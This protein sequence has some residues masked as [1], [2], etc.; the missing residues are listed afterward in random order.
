M[1]K[2]YILHFLIATLTLN[3]QTWEAYTSKNNDVQKPYVQVTQNIAGDKIYSIAI[4]NNRIC[5]GTNGGVTLEDDGVFTYFNTSNSSL[6]ENTIKFTAFDSSGNAW[7][8]SNNVLTLYNGDSLKHF[9]Y[10]GRDLPFYTI[11]AMTVDTNGKLWLGSLGLGIFEY[12]GDDFI[13]H[14]DPDSVLRGHAVS[15]LLVDNN[16]SKWVGTAQYTVLDNGIGAFKYNGTEWE[17]FDHDNSG[18][19]SINIKSMEMEDDGTLWFGGY[20]WNG[21]T[22]YDGQQ[23]KSYYQKNSQI[24]PGSIDCIAIDTKGRKWFGNQS[25]GLSMYDGNKWTTFNT[26]NSQLESNQILSLEAH[27]D[28]SMYIGTAVGLSVY[29]DNI[30]NTVNE[31]N[32]IPPNVQLL[33]NYPN[34]FNGET[35]IQY[36]VENHA[37]IQI[38][39]YNTRGQL[40]NTL[41][42]GKQIPGQHAV[43]WNGKN[44]V[45]EPVSSGIYFV[46]LT[47]D[48]RN[49]ETKRLVFLK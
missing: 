23:W 39:I 22:R 9:T 6:P 8:A 32:K 5:Y 49:V 34:P 48:Q 2:Q 24:I 17:L 42:R 30:V 25:S 43:H 3:A 36:S 15:A 28:G 44:D 13:Q 37:D 10:T 31:S 27:P 45:G 35:T 41:F 12:N 47:T 40:I 38:R 7:F 1:K 46:R 19:Y 33:Q 29:N 18:I 16:D 20:E 21:V 14:L 26:V 11:T 4:N